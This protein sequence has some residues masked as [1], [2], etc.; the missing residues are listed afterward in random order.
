MLFDLLGEIYISMSRN[1]LRIALTGFSIAWG[2]FMLIVLLGAGNGLL[3]GMMSNFGS[4]AQN[5]MRL[6]PGTTDTEWHGWAKGRRI[7]FDDRTAEFL[8]Q[9]F[10]DHIGA[11]TP[12]VSDSKVIACGNEYVSSDVNG[13][14]AGMLDNGERIVAGR[15]INSSDISGRRKVILLKDQ[16][17]PSLFPGCEPGQVLGR[18]VN[19]AGIPFQVVGIYHP[20]GGDSGHKS[21]IPLSTSI[22]LFSPDGHYDR[23][24]LE[25]LGLHTKEENEA[26]NKEV[27]A[28]LARLYDYN[29]EDHAV[30][31]WN[32]HENYLQT[33]SI[34]T[35][36]Q[37]FIWII[38]LA[39]L[40][41]GIAGISNIMM[42]T[43]RERT[44]EIGIRKA[45]GASPR[46]IL[47]L[48]LLEAVFITMLFGYIG[49]FLGIALTQGIDALM[50]PSDD[51]QFTM[52]LHPTVGLG[53]VMAANLVMIIAGI[54]AGY[55]PAKRA[56]SIKPV[57]ALAAQ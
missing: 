22:A 27:R 50:A 2:I 57:E 30:W 56:V 18:W 34:F 55:I 26:F 7:Q 8:Q 15:R 52:F 16:S 42:I 37:S 53:I 21:Y 31:I 17:L 40:I 23:L 1:K 41:A 11:V 33:R 10:P 14:A 19:V 47:W 39:T 38:G 6:Y 36:I 5:F 28:A 4:D 32:N 35:A 44:R 13:V 46:S 51:K 3:N 54:I 24:E 43:V 48:V 45:L 29:P 9:T 12:K 20:R 25:L 49:M